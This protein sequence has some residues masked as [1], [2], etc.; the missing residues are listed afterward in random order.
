[1][2]RLPSHSL[3][4]LL[5]V[6][7]VL[8]ASPLHAVYA[9]IPEQEQGKDLT[10]TLRA[11]LSYDTNLFGAATRE[12]E[13]GVFTTGAAIAYNTS[14]S[15][16]TFFSGSYGL[17]LDYFEN[18]PGD[19]L[20]DSHDLSL[21][22]AHAFSRVTTLDVNNVFVSSR[23]PESL[24]AGVPLNPDQSYQS[25]QLDARF[26]LPLTP[27]IGGTV[28]ARSLYYDYRDAALGRSLD[29]IENL[30]GVAGDYALLPEVKAVA[31]YRRLEIY[32]R[33]LGE[34][35]NKRSDFVMGGFDYE[36]ARK[37]TLS[38]RLGTEWRQRSSERST[39]APFAELSGKYEYARDSFLVGGYAHSLDETSDAESFTDMEVNR[40][41]L[42]VQHRLTGLIAVSG[43]AGYEPAELKGRRGR[44]GIDE[45]T[46]RW[47]AALSYLPR[48][49]WVASATYDYDRVRS[50]EAVRGMT[51][52]RVGVSARFSF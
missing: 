46:I 11:G 19:K 39:T 35:K 44:A 20:L 10:T 43:S 45:T 17:T 3:L 26:A 47:G 15:D 6:V 32:Y 34:A 5:A 31:E 7:A 52:Q 18:R 13:T 12:V 51:R 4:H 27:K 33:K 14:L 30:Y 41:F 2:L 23:N 8:A 37:L 25:N 24:L 21:R 1:M 49:N 40:F 16:Q 38:G 48:K 29:R 22:L 28:K 50:D 42:N 9:P 36:L